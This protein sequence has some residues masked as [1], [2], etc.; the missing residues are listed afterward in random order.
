MV[1]QRVG[2]DWGTELN[3]STHFLVAQ[4]VK[5]PP[6]MQEAW[7]NSWLRKFPW[8]RDRL[9]TPTFLGFLG[10]SDA[11]EST[12]NVGDLGSIPDLERSP[13]GGHGNSLQYF[14]LENPHGQKS[15]TGYSPWSRKVRHDWVTKQSTHPLILSASSPLGSIVIKL[16]IKAFWGGARVHTQLFKAGA[17][18]VP[19]CLAK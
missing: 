2:H 16:F 8:I 18:C 5:N 9:P 14:C 12:Y 19:L 7:F 6:A 17:R 11:K 10:G 4:L 13:G 1:S 3:W 15:L